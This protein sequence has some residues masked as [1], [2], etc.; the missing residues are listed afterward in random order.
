MPLPVHEGSTCSWLHNTALH[1]LRAAGYLEA[2]LWVLAPNSRA[3]SFYERRGWTLVP[4]KILEW[5]GLDTI[6]VRYELSLHGPNRP[7]V[8]SG[9][10]IL[11]PRPLVPSTA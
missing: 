1:A 4:D 5:P 2:G 6:E 11:S 9:F 8:K 10:T 7:S 3:R